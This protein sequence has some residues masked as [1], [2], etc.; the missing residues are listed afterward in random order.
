MFWK[1]TSDAEVI[2]RARKNLQQTERWGRWAAAFH[3]GLAIVM[4]LAIA[5]IAQLL[6]NLAVGAQNRI[7]F[8]LGL[9]MG[10]FLGSALYQLMNAVVSA[11]LAKM[12][13]GRDRLLVR[14]HDALTECVRSHRDDDREAL[15]LES[16]DLHTRL[17]TPN[18]SDPLVGNENISLVDPLPQDAQLIE[19]VEQL[20]RIAIDPKCS[21]TG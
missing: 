12:P 1:V 16:T 21:C 18:R 19:R 4:G 6:F 14:Y 13:D 11:R 8:V 3:L 7:E 17:Q 5:G 15:N 2:A 20:R 9:T 10:V